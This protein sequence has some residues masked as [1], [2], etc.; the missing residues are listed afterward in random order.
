MK[1]PIA[2]AIAFFSQVT[3]AS[4]T[5]VHLGWD[6]VTHS[7]DVVGYEID[8]GTHSHEY[9]QSQI[10][11]GAASSDAVVSGLDDHTVY[12]FAIRSMNAAGNRF[13]TYS[14]EV[15]NATLPSPGNLGSIP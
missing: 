1:K 7:P 10:V 4:T 12:Y 3:F 6:A 13:S 9:T 11:D 15:N 5:S 2:F 8:Y 14:N